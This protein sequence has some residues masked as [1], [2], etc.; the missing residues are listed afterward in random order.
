MAM[1]F[2]VGVF[3]AVTPCSVAV[4]FG[5]PF[6]FHFQGEVNATLPEHYTASQS[7]RLR[8]DTCHNV[9]F[10]KVGPLVLKL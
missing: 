3:W 9:H 1:K 2:Q 5:A 8:L 6:C 10:M 4:R 7:R